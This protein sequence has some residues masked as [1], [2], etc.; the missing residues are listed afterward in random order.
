[1]NKET[2]YSFLRKDVVMLVGNKKYAEVFNF[3]HFSIKGHNLQIGKVRIYIIK[4]ALNSRIDEKI[5]ES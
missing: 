1:M 2:L 3:F 4:R 5:T